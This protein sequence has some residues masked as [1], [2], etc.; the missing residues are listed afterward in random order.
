MTSGPNTIVVDDR[1]GDRIA[2]RAG[3]VQVLGMAPLKERLGPKWNRLSDLVHKLFET[4]IRRVQGP[5]DHFI[6][7]DELSYL[8]TFRDLSF[9]ETNLACTAIAREACQ[10][11]FGDQIGEVTVRSLVAAIL[12]PKGFD[13]NPSARAID[14]VLEARGTET[15][16]AQSVHTGSSGPVVFP[17]EKVRPA[18]ATSFAEIERAHAALEALGVRLG[19]FPVWELRKASASSVFLVPFVDSGGQRVATGR[20]AL[21]GLSDEKV[22]EI[23]ISLLQAAFAYASRV[24][25]EGRLCATGIGV[26]YATLSMFHSRIRFVT[27]LQKKKTSP[28]SP[29]LLKIEQIPDGAPIARIAE[30]VAMFRFPNV[31]VTVEF[32]HLNA[33]PDLDIRIGAAGLGGSLPATVDPEFAERMMTRLAHRV[34]GQ[35]AFAFIDRLD[36]PRL[37]ADAQANGIRF[38]TGAAL[39]SRH[40]SGLEPLPTFPLLLTDMRQFPYP[41]T[42]DPPDYKRSSL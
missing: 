42:V 6:A 15:I 16:V 17:S 1:S 19:L 11:L 13:L 34:A 41:V 20:R 21:E 40:L 36:T 33:M 3:K 25:Q 39:S 4:A 26:S 37:L 30:L 28:S 2:L 27:A 32:Q 38:G 31:R 24:H 8:V 18:A 7:V 29:L 14:S 35:K 23:E 9:E 10:M 5:S 12:A 22:T